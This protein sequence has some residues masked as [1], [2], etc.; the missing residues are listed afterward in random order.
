MS[1]FDPFGRVTTVV[2][3]QHPENLALARDLSGGHVWPRDV[4]RT[5]S[6]VLRER[7][8]FCFAK[9]HLLAAPL[10][11]TGIPTGFV[12]SSAWQPRA[13]GRTKGAQS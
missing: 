4:A 2:D 3:W 7:T 10:R 13:R 9:S 1:V 12:P 6:E 8:G 11:A 5:A